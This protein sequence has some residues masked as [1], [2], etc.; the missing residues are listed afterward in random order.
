MPVSRLVLV[1][2]LVVC[3]DG[4]HAQQPAA[5]VAGSLVQSSE[6]SSSQVYVGTVVPSRHSS[7]GA[8]VDGRIAEIHV[9]EGDFVKKG[10][11]LAQLLTETIT[12]ERD[13]AQAELTL[14]QYELEELENGARPDEINEAK[15]RMLAAKAFEEFRAAQRE[16]TQRLFKE[17]AVDIETLHEVEAESDAA[18][19]LHRQAEAALKLIEAGPR[20]EQI[21]QA[22]ARVLRQDAIVHNLE[23]RIRKHTIVAPF[24]GYVV[25][26]SAEL[27]EWIRQGDLA[28]D[29]VALDRVDVL[30]NVLETHVSHIQTGTEV[31]VDIPA[32]SDQL[33]T[34][35]VAFVVPQADVRART[36]PVKVRIENT[37]SPNGPL[38]KAGMLAR[39]ALPTGAKHQALLVAKDALVLGGASPIVYVV[40][41]QSDGEAKGGKVRPVPVKIGVPDGRLIEVT[42]PLTAGE[43]V[44]V[45]GNERLRPGQ[46]VSIIDVLDPRAEPQ[47]KATGK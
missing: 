31:R 16:R 17:K 21:L 33:I 24:D 9:E 28:A 19:Q 29:V 44:V 30:V 13:A 22:R 25:A 15:A 35:T 32:L 6:L 43:M 1:A 26:R 10:A 5:A 46:D 4:A 8:A 36:F 2:A 7:V 47:A 18:L 39:V 42:G 37:I 27:G 34:G 41:G 12:L 14:R 23:A 20:I 45:R 38:I 11:R 40:D 3:A